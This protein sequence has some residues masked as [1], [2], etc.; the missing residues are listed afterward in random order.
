M[1]SRRLSTTKIG[2][3]QRLID[4]AMRLGART[5]SATALGLRE[6]AREAR[7]NPNTFYRH[8]DSLDD[9]GL[10]LIEQVARPLRAS[11]RQVRRD[12]GARGSGFARTLAV[13]H[14]STNHF[15]DHVERHPHAFPMAVRELHGASPVLRRALARVLAEFTADMAEDIEKLELLPGLPE[16]TVRELSSFVIQ[17]LFFW[18]LDYLEHAGRRRDIRARAERLIRVV[19]LGA[20]ADHGRQS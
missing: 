6:L 19:F 10:A 20:I 12:A 5:R 13:N 2:G 8:F 14:E 18:S 7:L 1:V 11:I 3:R 4:A 15:F 16:A 17:Q 9:L